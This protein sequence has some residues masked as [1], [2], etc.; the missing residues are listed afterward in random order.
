MEELAD[1]FQQLVRDGGAV[2]LLEPPPGAKVLSAPD[3]RSGASAFGSYSLK[4]E[5]GTH[6][7]TV[8]FPGRYG[9]SGGVRQTWRNLA[10]PAR[11]EAVDERARRQKAALERQKQAAMQRRGGHGR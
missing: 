8:E 11:G 1:L 5:P 7:V 2:A 4:V 3:S 9:G 6:E 10:V